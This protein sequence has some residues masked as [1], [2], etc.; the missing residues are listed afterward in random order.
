VPPS[1]QPGHST[2]IAER[3]DLG[4]P[5]TLTGPTGRGEVGQV[6]QLTTPRG[7]W[8]VKETF[9]PI[10]AAEVDAAARQQEAALLGGVPT[11]AVVRTTDGKP[12]AV[13]AGT[14]TRVFAWVDLLE[15]DPGVD[16]V[17]VGAVLA[18]IHRV[19][20]TEGPPVDP[21]YTEPVGAR[22]WDEL[23]AALRRASSPFADRLGSLRDG[24]VELETW[25]TPPTDLQVC[26]R[27]LWADNLR[28]TAG[29]G[30]CVIDWDECG[31][32]EPSHELATALFEFGL[33]DP[34]RA[35]RLAASY[36]DHG[37][38]GRVTGRGSFSMAIAQ[39]GH[40]GERACAL[41]LVPTSDV[42]ERDRAAARVDEFTSRALTPAKVDALV[43]AVT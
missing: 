40:L 11:P 24:L 25:L 1:L 3:F 5:A 12:D 39:L 29:G 23:V 18:A 4:L 33:D 22:R 28:A 15:P 43:A 31:L 6:W 27:D 16:P 30:L 7:T 13:I 36:C 8:A 19:R 17:A 21:W 41:H 38:P 37:G 34:D 26:H 14:C 20:R 42:A 9:E 35:R 32:A 10:S 2:T